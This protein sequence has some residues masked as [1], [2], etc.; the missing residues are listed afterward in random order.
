MAR[1]R[2]ATTPASALTGTG[3]AV[4]GVEVASL[5]KTEYMT[6]ALPGV[7]PERSGILV[8]GHKEIGKST[9]ITALVAAWTGGPAP[10]GWI[11]KDR[12]RVCVIATEDIWCLHIKPRLE[13]GCANLDRVA[14]LWIDLPDG[15]RRT[16]RIPSD[17][18]WIEDAM[19]A[20]G[21]DLLV[22]DPLTGARDG[23]LDLKDDNASD[24]M[25]SPLLRLC[26]RR[27]FTWIS[28]RNM[29]KR[30]TGSL[31]DRGQ[32]GAG[33]ANRHRVVLHLDHHPTQ[34]GTRVCL[35]AAGNYGPQPASLLYSIRGEKDEFGFV[36]WIGRE[37]VSGKRLGVIPEAPHEAE[38]VDEAQRVLAATIGDKWTP[39]DIVKAACNDAG[40]CA[41]AVRRA[42]THLQVGW[43]QVYRGGKNAFDLG[44]PPEGWPA[45]LKFKFGQSEK[46]SQESQEGQEGIKKNTEKQG[47]SGPSDPLD[48][49][50]SLVSPASDGPRKG[51]DEH[52]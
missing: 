13:V 22:L 39:L 40:I 5:T 36:Q 1:K 8:Q 3:V 37:E 42:R 29:T 24:A 34:I 16:P 47:F 41:T 2:K 10:P 31:V 44:P 50:D 46:E 51:V 7:I 20:W 23:N 52:A 15:G 4:P 32:Y 11:A 49:L 45:H 14:H 26:E 38:E 48:S 17:L 27:Q 35:R 6:W 9:F 43:R 12:G 25:L 18:P 30:S 21:A 19:Q 28:A 33:V